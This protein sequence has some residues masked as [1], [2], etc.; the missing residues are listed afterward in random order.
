[1]EA[2][3]LE[4]RRSLV[5]GPWHV[6]D[7]FDGGIDR[8]RAELQHGPRPVEMWVG[9]VM[10]GAAVLWPPVHADLQRDYAGVVVGARRRGAA[11]LTVLNRRGATCVLVIDVFGRPLDDGE[12]A[13]VRRILE[14]LKPQPFFK[15]KPWVAV[16]VGPWGGFTTSAVVRELDFGPWGGDADVLGPALEQLAWVLADEPSRAAA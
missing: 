4:G 9:R 12:Q 1:V 3:R 2:T 7:V 10:T 8:R 14:R 5:I 15:I 13:A 16:D 6:P 11:L